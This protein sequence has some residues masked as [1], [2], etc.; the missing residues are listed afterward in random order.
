MKCPLQPLACA[1]ALF[2][3]ISPG[4]AATLTYSATLSGAAEET[5]NDSP[6]TGEALVTIDLDTSSMRVQVEFADLGAVT[7]AAHI[8]CCTPDVG[9]KIAGV[10]SQTP[11]YPGFPAGVTAGTYDATFDMTLAGSFNASFVNARGGTVEGAFD[12]LLT[13]L[14]TG[15]AYF[16]IHTT[17]FGG[18]EIRGFFAPVPEPGATL[19]GVAAF[20]ALA[21]GRA[22]FVRA[23]PSRRS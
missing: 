7:T 6:G 20:G 8:H 5:P 3:G 11:T 12:A 15:T 1:L 23:R 17:T 22:R 2:L 19:L 9:P 14:D 21:A 4:H 16:N 10:A 13:G 18:G